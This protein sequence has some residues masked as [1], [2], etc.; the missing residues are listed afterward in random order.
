MLAY[1]VGSELNYQQCVCIRFS[2]W[3]LPDYHIACIILL[4]NIFGSHCISCRLQCLV[5]CAHVILIHSM[6]GVVCGGLYDRDRPMCERYY[7][8]EW[9]P[10]FVLIVDSLFSG[11]CETRVGWDYQLCLEPCY[12]ECVK[13]PGCLL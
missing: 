10:F 11:W 1:F 12:Y 8:I 13:R 4:G 5:A 3:C 9:K 6:N 7:N 2:H